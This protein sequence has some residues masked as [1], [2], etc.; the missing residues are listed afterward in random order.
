MAA[1]TIHSEFRDKRKSV[2]ASTFSPSVCHELMGPD[3]MILVFSIFSIKLAFSLTSFTLIKRLFSSS[4]LSAIS[5][6]S[7]ACLRL[8]FLLPILIPA[9]YSPSPAFLTMCSAWRLNKQ[10]RSRRACGAPFS[11]LNQSVVPHRVLLFVRRRVRWSGIPVSLRAFQFVVIHTVKGFSAV[12]ETEVDVF[13]ELP[14]FL[15]NPVNVGSL[16]SG[17]SSFS[18]PSLEVLG[19]HKAE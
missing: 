17:S 10:G 6:V 19:S 4:S 18:K 1:V 14:S 8:M 3:A 7:S 2:T 16:S 5:M 15:Y 9:C 11:I 13:L 12:N